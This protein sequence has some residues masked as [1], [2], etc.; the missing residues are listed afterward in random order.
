MSVSHNESD[1][2]PRHSPELDQTG[3][4][5]QS[6][7]SVLGATLTRDYRMPEDE[8]EELVKQAVCQR[9]LQLSRTTGKGGPPP[10]EK[11][12]ESWCV[13]SICSRAATLYRQRFGPEG[14][15]DT[16]RE[17]ASALELLRLR[18]AFES[19]PANEQEAVRL[20][21]YED[22]PLEA[23]AKEMKWSVKTTRLLIAKS[24]EKLR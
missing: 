20:Y 16:D 17:T 19:L 6:L 5:Y 18:R 4:L 15:P 24:L 9:L 23:V 22:W 21:C 12:N 13:A 8:A 7:K 1:G 14:V 10:S 3:R 2:R 11:E